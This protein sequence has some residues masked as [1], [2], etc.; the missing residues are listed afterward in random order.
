M[1]SR[2]G[3]VL[4]VIFAVGVGIAVWRMVVVER[5]KRHLAEEYAKAAQMVEQLHVEQQQ[6]TTQLADARQTVEGQAGQISSLHQELEGVD[7]QLKETVAELNALQREH[8]ELRQSH[9]ALSQQF[10]SLNEEKRQL[11]AR[12]SSLKELKLAIREVKRKMWNQRWAAWRA[13]IEAQREADQAR[14][15][16]GNRG[17]VIRNGASTIT[18]AS[19]LQVH[20]LEPQPQ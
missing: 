7:K 6:L 2:R 9:A 11:E 12:L 17:Y 8:Q 16:A 18:A 5:Q 15:A 4:L 20:V 14:L 3:R 19:R 10:D 1:A 13:R